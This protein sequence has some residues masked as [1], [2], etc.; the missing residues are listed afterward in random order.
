M[1]G[2][3]GWKTGLGKK[4]GFL[5]LFKKKPL[6]SLKNP[7]FRVFLICCAIYDRKEI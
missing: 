1:S 7:N 3:Q 6:K 2:Y 4:Q 5:G